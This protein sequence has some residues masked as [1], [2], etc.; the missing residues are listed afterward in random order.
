MI[1]G[2][3]ARVG[4]KWSER[5]KGG[6]HAPGDSKGHSPWRFFGDFLIGEKVTRVQGGAPAY[7]GVQRGK[8][9]RIQEKVARGRRGGAPSSL[10]TGTAVPQKPQGEGAQRPPHRGAQRG[11][12]EEQPLA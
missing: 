3:P 10:G 4:T 11:A 1:E 12:P 9:P 5:E 6:D 8:A 7:W 2:S